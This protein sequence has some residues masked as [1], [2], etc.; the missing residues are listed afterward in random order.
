MMA[1]DE[2]ENEELDEEDLEVIKENLGTEIDRK[3]KSRLKR[4]A[5][6]E[7]E[8]HAIKDEKVE[9]DSEQIDTSSKPALV[10]SMS[11]RV[12]DQRLEVEKHESLHRSGSHVNQDQIR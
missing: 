10:K 3:K 9:F 1:K 11:S 2:H 5:D 8:K 6:L 4:N 12:K 7:A